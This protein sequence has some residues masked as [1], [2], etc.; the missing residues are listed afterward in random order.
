MTLGPKRE[1]QH[2]HILVLGRRMLERPMLVHIQILRFLA[3]LAVVAFHVLGAPP[4]GFEV[5]DSALTF[6]VSYGGRG[7][8][9]FF[10]ISGF[11]IFYATH[12]SKLTPAEF[13][14]RRVERIVPLYFFVIFTVTV[15]AV[16]L[17]ATFG[18]P[19]WYTP[20]HIL[21]SLAFAAFT[22]GDMPVVYVGWSLEYEMYFYLAAA[23]LMAATRDA[24]RNIVVIFSALAIVGRIPGVEPALGNYAF[25]LDP[26]IF[27]FVFGVIVGRVFVTG[28]VDWPMLVAAGCAVIAV[29]VT[30][31]TQ[32]VII[33]G[34]P[35]AL[36][37]MAAA[38]VS[39]KRT[40]PSGPERV[41][42]R[43]GDA[44]Y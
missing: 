41:L 14:R 13:L 21:K 22:D 29:L 34:I 24:W 19:D 4:P 16:T 31:P 42:A 20:R 11:V 32:R 10:V 36:L 39:R 40:N 8:D 2:P 3:A 35:S 9:L 5:P 38:F 23:L 1:L 28:R 26:M 17:P 7:V 12:S 6:A 15:L 33:S 30:D 18:A 27:E 25:F 37:V 43:L 44:S